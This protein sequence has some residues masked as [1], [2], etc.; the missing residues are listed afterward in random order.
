MTNGPPRIFDDRAR[1]RALER[2]RRIGGDDFLA[3]E[4]VDGLV[5]RLSAVNRSF[6]DG[7]VI[8]GADIVRKSLAPFAKTW[9]SADIAENDAVHLSPESFD[10]AVSALA[11]H[12]VN[13]LPGVLLQIRHALRPDGLFLAAV[14]GG[15]TLHE[16]REALTAAEI[17]TTGGASPQIAPFADVRDFGSLLQRAGFAR[18]RWLIAS[19]RRFT[20]VHSLAS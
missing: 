15:A 11:L 13:D 4:A 18:C 1:K 5:H 16:L 9:T 8:A 2:A 17:E 20:I 3:R 19:A 10:V 6:T 12:A 14:L 7:V